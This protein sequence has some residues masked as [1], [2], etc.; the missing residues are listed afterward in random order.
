MP[1]TKVMTVRLDPADAR[2]ADL[3]AR[4]EEISVNEVVR[5]A[6]QHYFEVKRADAGFVAR[7]RALVAEDAKLVGGLR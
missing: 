6:L 4:T 2:R 1:S 5:R 3:V 7:A